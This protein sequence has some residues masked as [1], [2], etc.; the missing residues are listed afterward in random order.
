MPRFAPAA[1]DR[2][3]VAVSEM[4]P[5]HDPEPWTEEKHEDDDA[6]LTALSTNAFY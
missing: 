5:S 4:R 1:A 3:N 6:G 2:R